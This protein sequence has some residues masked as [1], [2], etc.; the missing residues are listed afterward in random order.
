M[1]SELGRTEVTNADFK[2]LAKVTDGIAARAKIGHLNA[3]R[4]VE[5]AR[6]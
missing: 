2:E 3:L 6:R 5:K 1:G 4:I